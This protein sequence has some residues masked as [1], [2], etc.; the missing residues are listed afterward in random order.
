[1]IRIPFEE[2]AKLSAQD[3][4]KKLEKLNKKPSLFQMFIQVILKKMEGKKSPPPLDMTVFKR[5]QNFFK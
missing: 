5:R 4:D 2:W 3:R 1:M